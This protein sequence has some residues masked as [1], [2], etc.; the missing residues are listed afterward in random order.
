MKPM[1]KGRGKGTS[2]LSC[3]DLFLALAFVAFGATACFYTVQFVIVSICQ[4]LD[5]MK[6]QLSV[7]GVQLLPFLSL[8]KV[9]HI[10]YFSYNALPWGLAALGV[11]TGSK[12]LLVPLQICKIHLA[13]TTVR[14]AAMQ[15]E[16][17]F[18]KQI[19]VLAALETFEL[20]FILLVFLVMTCASSHRPLFYY[21]I[22]KDDVQ[23]SEVKIN[24]ANWIEGG[25]VD[26]SAKPKSEVERMKEKLRKKEE[27]LVAALVAAEQGVTAEDRETATVPTSSKA[28]YPVHGASISPV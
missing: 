24:M 1:R 10:S 14:E 2:S 12:L 27:E 21:N 19:D 17:N 3:S 25:G 5:V 15:W 13:Y 23:R 16:G 6:F 26:V 18:E 20:A 7:F 8:D 4:L 28:I 9:Q 22:A 11:F